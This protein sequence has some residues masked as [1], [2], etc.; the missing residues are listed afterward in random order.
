MICYRHCFLTPLI[1]AQRMFFLGSV[2]VYINFLFLGSLN[3]CE[4][5]HRCEY[6]VLFCKGMLVG[7]FLSKSLHSAPLKSATSIK[8]WL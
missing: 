4:F 1:H 3:V 5:F 7:Y 2:Y 6:F 8:E